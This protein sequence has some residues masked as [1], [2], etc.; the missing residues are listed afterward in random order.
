MMGPLLANTPATHQRRRGSALVYVTSAMVA[1]LAFA[2]LAVDVGHVYVV[3]HELQLAADAGARYGVTGIA[4]G[5]TTA[6]N[7]AVDAADDNKADGTA[8][9]IDP[10]T[11][12]EFLNWNKPT[13]T[14]T[15]LT[16]AARSSANALR[17][18]ARRTAANGGGVQLLFARVLGRTSQDVRASSI[19]YIEDR[20]PS[21]IIGLNGITLNNNTF[22]ASYNSA[23]NTNPTASTASFTG[24]MGSNGTITGGTNNTLRG[25]VALGPSAP[26]ATGISISGTTTRL[27]TPMS[28]PADP[29]WTPAPN[30]NG[31][32]QNY[33][34]TGG[35][36][37][38]GG[39]YWFT[40]I[41]I[42]GS[43]RFSGPATLYVN[44]PIMVSGSLQ[45][46]SQIPLDLQINQLGN[47]AFND[48]DFNGMD[49]VADVVAP[50]AAFLAKNNLTF[51]GRMIVRSIE[52]LNNA[53]F[54]YDVA[55][56]GTG[57]GRNVITVR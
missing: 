28:G 49:I 20:R 55:L 8:V 12:V 44:G 48:D 3:K 50:G 39:T 17:V 16:G 46:L 23:A 51:R 21:G 53:D 43:L 25:D 5:V 41:N 52:V 33:T 10:I 2:S 22:V 13:R 56:G 14:Y 31:V 7:Y 36:T 57:L 1:L 19:A 27:S 40:S 32:P 45:P 15:V 26:N 38:P 42:R 47:Y 54:Y 4:A 29:A 37:L 9:V 18:T 11:D 24:S 35:I 34:A 30:P 6:Q